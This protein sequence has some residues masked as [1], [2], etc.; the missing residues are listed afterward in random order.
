[1]SLQYQIPRAAVNP[2]FVV[3]LSNETWSCDARNKRFSFV[4]YGFFLLPAQE[5]NGHG[6]SFEI[7]PVSAFAKKRHL[8]VFLYGRFQ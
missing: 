2:T 3:T 7:E 1:V 4:R 5:K 6:P 8:V